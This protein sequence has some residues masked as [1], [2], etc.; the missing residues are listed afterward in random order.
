ML[1]KNITP[2]SF[3]N[4]H[5]FTLVTQNAGP[6]LA[7]KY[8]YIFAEVKSLILLP[9][10]EFTSTVSL[11]PGVCLQTHRGGFRT[12]STAL[13][14]ASSIAPCLCSNDF[15]HFSVISQAWNSPG[16]RMDISWYI[17]LAE[18]TYMRMNSIVNW[19]E[20]CLLTSEDCCG[21]N[22]NAGFLSL[23]GG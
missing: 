12:G 22:C 9:P 5:T 11:L 14:L 16:R 7:T 2:Q 10:L 21:C 19:R 6:L 17:C 3:Y 8:F 20:S 15:L 13:T 4:M 23:E 1:F 18:H